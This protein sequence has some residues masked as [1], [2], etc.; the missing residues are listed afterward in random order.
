MTDRELE[1]QRLIDKVELYSKRIEDYSGM[2]GEFWDGA[3]H[4]RRVI[5]ETLQLWI[6]QYRKAV[7]S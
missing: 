4:Q 1:A 6:D 2:T 7:G 3:R 5:C